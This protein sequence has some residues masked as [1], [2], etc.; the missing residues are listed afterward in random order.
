M[1]LFKIGTYKRKRLDKENVSKQGRNLKTRI[2]E[3]DF[4][5]DFDDIDDMVDKAME[6]VEGD[7]VNAAIGVSAASASVTTASVSISTAEP[8]TPPTITTKAFEDKD[9]TI[10]Q[11][12]VK[13]RS[14]KAKEKR[15]V[16]NNMEEF[17]RPTTILPTIDPKDK[18]KSIMQ[19]PKKPPKN[20]RKAQ[21]HMD[22]ELALRLHEEEKSKLKKMQRDIYAK[23]EASNAALTAE[24]DDVQARM[25]ADA[26][27]AAKL[28]EEERE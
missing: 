11:T 20:L 16:F 25:N 5:D 2:E 21:T 22:E 18:G 17:A 6:N 27:L 9:L 7:T 23:E 12:L 19:E 13:M 24:F 15:V 26:L 3:G 28:Q 10:A 8:R 1:N 4:Y 14:K